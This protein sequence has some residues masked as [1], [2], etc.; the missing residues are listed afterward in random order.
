MS[1]FRA[2]LRHRWTMD[3]LIPPSRR[4]PPSSTEPQSRPENFPV[5]DRV[6][7]QLRLSHT[8]FL[9]ISILPSFRDVRRKRARCAGLAPAEENE[10]NNNKWIK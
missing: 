6:L 10:N 3:S 1:L 8:F 4:G 9:G 7:V 5:D 2:Q